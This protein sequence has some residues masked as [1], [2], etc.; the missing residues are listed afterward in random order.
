MQLSAFLITQ[1]HQE[2]SVTSFISLATASTVFIRLSWEL[3]SQTFLDE[4]EMKGYLTCA[5]SRKPWLLQNFL[6]D[7]IEP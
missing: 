7:N 1:V 5:K 3:Y 6:Q 4:V 2:I